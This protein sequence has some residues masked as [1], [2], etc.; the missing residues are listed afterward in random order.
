M[1]EH[2][3]L[4]LM[5]VGV[6][7]YAVLGGADFGAGIWDLTAGT[8][9][10][11]AC[12]RGVIER[13]MGPVWEANHVWLIFVLVVCW[14][15]FPAFFGSMV[16]SLWVPMAIA[17][18]G[19]ILRGSA[20][21]LRGQ[22]ATINEARAFGA[23]FALSSVLVPF[24]F[25]TVA[26]AIA[27]GRVVYGNA[28]ADTWSVFL[29]PFSIY[30]GVL[31]VVLSAYMAAIFLVGDSVRMGEA[32]IA[33]AFRRRA[34]GA[35]VAGGLLAIAGLPIA[36]SEARYLYDGLTSGMGLVSVIVSAAAGALTLAMIARGV[37]QWPRL[38]AAVAVGAVTAGWGFAQAPYLL[39][40]GTADSTLTL[41]EAA[42][43]NAT[44]VALTI[45]IVLALVF[46]VPALAWLFKL[47]L[48]GDLEPSARDYEDLAE[49][50][51]GF[52][53]LP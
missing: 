12:M 35:G 31:A 53:S 38:S 33:A 34:L 50:D 45:A 17:A 28:A 8:A 30:V 47:T 13:A 41:G 15:A 6:T 24:A 40:P 43:N 49:P 51:K 1:I 39:P 42:G 32:D 52:K 22:A 44:L 18:F 2:I 14:T 46:V 7:F 29:N 36:H 20:F 10:G 9:A 4:I 3:V 11:G 16:S 27:S 37:A 48:S 25:G 23:T 26:G 5:L 21:A 19:I